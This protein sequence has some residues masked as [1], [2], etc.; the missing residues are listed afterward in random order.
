MHVFVEVIKDRLIENIKHFITVAKLHQTDN[1]IRYYLDMRLKTSK[2]N[3]A[4]AII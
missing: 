2:K 1:F 4:R 3:I